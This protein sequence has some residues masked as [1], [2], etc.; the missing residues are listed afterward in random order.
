MP[1]DN[2]LGI[3]RG[4]YMTKKIDGLKNKLAEALAQGQFTKS[5]MKFVEKLQAELDKI[6]ND[7]MLY[8]DS[9]KDEKLIHFLQL[10]DNDPRTKAFPIVR[11]VLHDYSK[12][13]ENNLVGGYVL[14]VTRP[15]TNEDFLTSLNTNRQERELKEYIIKLAKRPDTLSQQKHD[16]LVN[17]FI[18]VN[19]HKFSDPVE[20]AKFIAKQLED[21]QFDVLKKHGGYARLHTDTTVTKLLNNYL[22]KLTTNK[23]SLHSRLF[24]YSTMI[25][26]FGTSKLFIAEN[27]ARKL[28]G[29]IR[30]L[31]SSITAKPS[32]T[33]D[34]SHQRLSQMCVNLLYRTDLTNEQK[35]V[36][37]T[38]KN[39]CDSAMKELDPIKLQSTLDLIG[40]SQKEFSKAKNGFDEVM[41]E[42]MPNQNK[43]TNTL[44]N[45]LERFRTLAQNKVSELNPTAALTY[46][47]QK[48]R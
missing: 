47:T 27:N 11:S 16:A 28:S 48:P 44:Q 36:A 24:T 3:R 40:R 29:S 13:L 4:I 21:P 30:K 26:K 25:K 20:K 22:T 9:K 32:S 35:E 42:L 17:L 39:M 33:L 8:L 10:F 7:K 12:E 37:V 34:E 1:L 18:S 19:K 41:K 15:M 14:S 23:P 2:T 31:T 5:E 38:I 45:E 6:N 46:E 43:E